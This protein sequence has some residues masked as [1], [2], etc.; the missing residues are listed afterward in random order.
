MLANTLFSLNEYSRAIEMLQKAVRLAP[1]TLVAT[2]PTFLAMQGRLA[3]ALLRVGRLAEAEELQRQIL[4]TNSSLHPAPQPQ[5]LV[6]ALNLAC[7]LEKLSRFKEA[8]NVL[9]PASKLAVEILSPTH[10]TLLR[11]QN[12]LALVYLRLGHNEDAEGQFRALVETNKLVYGENGE[13]RLIAMNN[14]GGALQRQGKYAEAVEVQRDVLKRCKKVLGGGSRRTMRAGNN[15]A[16]SLRMW[17]E[18]SA[19][20][21]EKLLEEAEKLHRGVLTSLKEGLGEALDTWVSSVNLGTVLQIQG[22]GDEAMG[23]LGCFGE[24]GG[25]CWQR[26]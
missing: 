8:R 15:L 3:D 11:F 23:V 6:P 26:Q 18:R 25:S 22:R 14:L 1:Q 24:V 19:E 7:T 2:H 4:D 17:A 9:E 21:G 20:S 10:P 16:E 5:S 12:T 13:R